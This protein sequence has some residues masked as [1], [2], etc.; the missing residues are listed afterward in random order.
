MLPIADLRTLLPGAL[1][2]AVL[3]FSDGIL[4]ARGFAAKAGYT[5][6]PS[7]E[8][9]A[10]AAANVAASLFQGFS[11]GASQ[12][13]T[14]VNQD[15]GGKT[16]V[17]SLVAVVV[18]ALFLLFFTPL[19]RELPTVALASILVF[20][21][22]GMCDVPAYRRLRQISPHAFVLAL[23]VTG[24]VLALGVAP[25]ILVGVVLSLVYLLVRL[26]RPTDIVLQEVAS[27]GGFHD[28]G[29]SGATQTVP[30]LIAYRFY[31]PLLFAN[32]DHFAERVRHLVA[33]S[34][35]PVRW[36]L[37]D[38]QAITTIDVT[39]ADTLAGLIVELRERAIAV[40]IARANRP[41]RETLARLGLGE[42][43]EE[44]N[45]FPSVHAAVAAFRRTETD[46]PAPRR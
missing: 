13:R 5:V 14:T 25:G 32:A 28:L 19:L 18:V 15:T 39:G 2:I 23:V 8:L 6:R 33:T 30:G 11:V 17:A 29:D 37:I 10:L 20:A 34:P 22:I 38:A 27:S 26:A 41:L 24:G 1:A 7:Q 42:E 44:A 9:R 46:R 12:S 35:T 4:M 40:K 21:G 16:Q 31:A 3:T 45:L 43:L 36:L